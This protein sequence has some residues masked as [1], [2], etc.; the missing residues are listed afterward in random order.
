MGVSY[1]EIDKLRSKRADFQ[2]GTVR[3]RLCVNEL[4]N[5]GLCTRNN[6]DLI[7]FS[8]V[9][10]KDFTVSNAKVHEVILLNEVGGQGG[11][12]HLPT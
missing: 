10:L 11:Q 4:T 3:L 1:S 12:G 9:Y 6:P 7:L 2:K 8:R 5:P